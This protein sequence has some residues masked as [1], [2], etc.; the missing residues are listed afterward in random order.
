LG[1]PK[2]SKHGETRADDRKRKEHSDD[3]AREHSIALAL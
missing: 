1:H 2:S 3:H